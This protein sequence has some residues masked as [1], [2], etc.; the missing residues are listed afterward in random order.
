V[1]KPVESR[2]KSAPNPPAAGQFGMDKPGVELRSY[3]PL[4]CPSLEQFEA[5][6]LFAANRDDQPER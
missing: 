3:R 6:F 2:P 5:R 1:L 4:G